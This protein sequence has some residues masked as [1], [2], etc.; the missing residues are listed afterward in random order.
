MRRRG[1]G[2]ISHRAGTKEGTLRMQGNNQCSWLSLQQN[3]LSVMVGIKR[4]LGRDVGA[5]LM[6]VK[7]GERGGDRGSVVS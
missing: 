4:A 5:T 6:G 1:D 3:K 7:G 2:V